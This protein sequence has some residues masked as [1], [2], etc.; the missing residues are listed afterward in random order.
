M[1][2]FCI[3]MLR[4]NI[5]TTCACSLWVTV[6]SENQQSWIKLVFFLLSTQLLCQVVYQK[7]WKY[8]QYWLTWWPVGVGK[9]N[10]CK[11]KKP[12]G[13]GLWPEV[14]IQVW[15]PGETTMDSSRQALKDVPVCCLKTNTVSFSLTKAA[16][17]L[18]LNVGFCF[19][20]TSLVSNTMPGLSPKSCTWVSSDLTENSYLWFFET[21]ICF[22]T[23]AQHR[24]VTICQPA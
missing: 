8:L 15:Y 9:R 24:E 7:C 11:I 21:S 6:M 3:L 2:I 5:L 13:H 1:G 12:A 16:R 17:R 4:L 19:I 23:S 20:S 10:R 14:K 22:W 18:R